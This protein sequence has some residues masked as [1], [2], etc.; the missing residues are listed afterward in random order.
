M[1]ERENGE[2]TKK[3]MVVG[4]MVCGYGEIDRYLKK[5]LDSFERL[6]DEV[7]IVGNNTDKK[8]EKEI[9][10]RGFWFYRD[11]REWGKY[12]PDIKTVLLEKVGKLKPTWVLPLDADEEHHPSFTKES[13]DE[14]ENQNE[15]AFHFYMTNLWDDE[16]HFAKG[17]S[18]WNIRM[19]R[20]LPEFGLQFARKRVHCGLA[21]PFAYKYGW[22]A[23]YIVRHYGLMRRDDREAKYQR[24][25]KYDPNAIFKGQEY[26]DSLLSRDNPASYDEEGLLRKL[27]ELPECNPRKKK[28]SSLQVTLM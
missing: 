27:K 28:P 4:M 12:Q 15:V 19:F 6:C 18:F 21:P 20:Y 2:D 26:Y 3:P 9:K 14:L 13:I 22:Y 16:E 7:V 23:P 11:D 5:P 17:L 8:T 10:K 1:D 25:Q 24:Y